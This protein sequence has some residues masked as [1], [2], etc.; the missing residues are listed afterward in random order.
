M[1]RLMKRSDV[2]EFGKFGNC[3]SRRAEDDLKTI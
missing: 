3:S 2:A 1:E